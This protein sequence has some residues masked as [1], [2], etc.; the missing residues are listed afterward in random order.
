MSE[1]VNIKRVAK[2]TAILYV[3]VLVVMLVSIY[4]S[5]VVLRILGVEDYGT[6]NVVAGA[7]ALFGFLNT[8]MSMATQRFLNYELGRKNEYGLK[9]VFNM[10]LKIHAFICVILLILAETLGLWLVNTQLDIPPQ[11]LTAALFAYQFAIISMLLNIISVPYT[12]AILAHEKMNVYA[13]ICIIEA[14]LKLGLVFLLPTLGFDK[15]IIYSILMTSVQ[16]IVFLSYYTYSRLKLNE[17][18][19]LFSFWDK[20]L[21]KQM[22]GFIGWN[23][24]GQIAQMLSVHGVNML[25]N[26]FYGVVVNA[27]M[28]ITNQVNGAIVMFVNNFQTSFRPQIMKSFAAEE[29]AE[30]NRMAAL[31]SKYSFYLLYILSVP[32]LFNI[33]IILD[34]W[35]ETPPEHTALFCKLVIWYSYLEALG[36]PLVMAIM[37][38]GRN[39]Y[40]Q[41][42]FSITLSLNIILSYIFL[43]FG[44]PPEIVFI[45]KVFVSIF[46]I[47][48]RILFAKKQSFISP[49]DFIVKSLVP[50][51]I[52]LAATLPIYYLLKIPYGTSLPID[53]ILTISLEIIIVLAIYF[54][55]INK[56]ERIF[57]LELV[58]IKRG[59]KK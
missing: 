34:I 38:S 45:I 36:M 48:I 14:L 30:V 42:F 12:S 51:A 6:Y 3:R 53:I 39:K 8:A 44:Y 57:L 37:A 17:C 56:H 5:R 2:N 22:S 9:S 20:S 1:S 27:A 54:I 29:Y 25:M 24:C 11:R 28:A 46:I 50:S 55:G 41:I 40:Y 23:I 47:T 10:A 49:K 7:V 33:D 15:L 26:V 19:L 16:I 31:F 32:I 35:L 59:G 43:K 13:Y 18:K 58:K 52:V 21:F 4:A